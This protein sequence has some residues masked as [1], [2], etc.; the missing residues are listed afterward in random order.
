MRIVVIGGGFA[1]IAA[2]EALRGTR[3]DRILVDRKETFD[4]LP[5]VPDVIGRGVRPSSLTV[6]LKAVCGRLRCDFVKAR[7]ERVDRERKAVVAG[8]RDIPYDQLLVA[9]GAEPN[10]FGNEAAASRGY[11][12][13]TVADAERLFLK[14]KAAAA[15]TYV[16]SGGGYT[17][18]EAATELRRY[19]SLR[20]L[21][22]KILLVEISPSV[23]GTLPPWIR[24]YCLANLAR[25]DI[26]VRT[27]TTVADAGEDWVSLS[28][29]SRLTD[30]TLVWSAGLKCPDFTSTLGAGRDRAGRMDVDAF[31]GIGPGVFAAGDAARFVHNGA[32]LRMAVQFSIM[33]GATAGTNIANALKGKKPLAYK[34]VDLGYIIP[35][36]NNR[37]CGIL[38]SFL[39]ARGLFPTFLHYAMCVYRSYGLKNKAGLARDVLF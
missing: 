36:S 10:F 31:L 13:Y 35:M 20:K 6:D 14:V 12:L 1:G 23:L 33:Q 7:V 30:A 19:F 26:E 2:L 27:N 28:D 18:V 39:R 17:G 32:P 22:K 15:D 11:T 24:R 5:A 16:V 38:F 21:P 34:P 25:M 29:G 9:S 37:S 3:A 8:G 4:F